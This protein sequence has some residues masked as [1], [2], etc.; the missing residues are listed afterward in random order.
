MSHFNLHSHFIGSGR[1]DWG[2]CRDL[3]VLFIHLIDD[4]GLIVLAELHF[5]RGWIIVNQRLFFWFK[6]VND[7]LLVRI[8]FLV[9]IVVGNLEL[10]L[11]EEPGG[12]QDLTDEEDRLGTD[13]GEEGEGSEYDE[14]RQA[15]CTHE[16]LDILT[17][18][19]PMISTGIEAGI[20]HEG[21]QELCQGDGS[22]D[23]QHHQGEEPLEQVDLESTDEIGT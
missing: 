9:R 23:H 12:V 5:L 15:W 11:V 13:I 6:V 3:R 22:P 10:H 14:R 1:S 19:G 8:H 21:C 17:D 4:D 18:I 20:G 16:I 2:C 7:L